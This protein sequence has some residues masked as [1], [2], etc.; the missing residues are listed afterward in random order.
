MKYYPKTL[1]EIFQIGSRGVFTQNLED[2]ATV[3][4]YKTKKKQAVLWQLQRNFTTIRWW[5][6]PCHSHAESTHQIFGTR[7]SAKSQCGFQT[8]RGK[9]DIIFA[10]RQVTKKEA[11]SNTRSLTVFQKFLPIENCFLGTA[12]HVSI[13][14]SKQ[15]QKDRL[16]KTNQ[17]VDG[18][19]FWWTEKKRA[20][21]T[22]YN[23][24]I[25]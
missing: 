22:R 20:R 19:L 10:A 17:G 21:V 23:S 25:R 15:I 24:T 18:R 2:A 8:S 5:Q 14:K 6:N 16:S 1:S 9:A 3:H 12:F 11:R 13:G 7:S 4:L